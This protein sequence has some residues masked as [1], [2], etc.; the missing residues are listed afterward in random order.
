M[1]ITCCQ[2]LRMVLPNSILYVRAIPGMD[3]GLFRKKKRPPTLFG[4]LFYCVCCSAPYYG[5]HICA[6]LYYDN[7]HFIEQSRTIWQEDSLD[8]LSAPVFIWSRHSLNS[9]HARPFDEI[10]IFFSDHCFINFS[11][12]PF[13]Y[14]LR[15]RPPPYCT[16]VH[17]I[18]YS[19]T[20]SDPLPHH[21]GLSCALYLAL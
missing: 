8:V 19:Q 15:W 18:A 4:S 6:L 17:Y 2:K 16:I 1:R 7:V 21:I 20:L 14:S 10:I 5:L 3:G 13:Y 9:W 11:F 12:V